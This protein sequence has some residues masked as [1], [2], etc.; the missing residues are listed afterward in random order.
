MKRNVNE[1]DT[2][3]IINIVSRDIERLGMQALPAK[4]VMYSVEELKKFL[5]ESIAKMLDSNYEK[6]LNALYMID[7]DEA[8]LH[9]LFAGENR[10][11]IP[12][13]LADMIIERQMQKIQ[14]RKKYRDSKI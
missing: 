11:F 6:L 9:D 5:T 3:E 8:R 13:T 4:Q 12:A 1:T 10:Q 14:F 2:R 7:L